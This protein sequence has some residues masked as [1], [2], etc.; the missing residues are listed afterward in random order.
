M[1]NPNTLTRLGFVKIIFFFF[2]FFGG[3]G[4]FQEELIDN[5]SLMLDNISSLS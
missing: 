2:F 5:I 4:S 3:G 1:F